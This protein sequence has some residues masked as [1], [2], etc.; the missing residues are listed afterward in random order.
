MVLVTLALFMLLAFTALAVDGGNIFVARNELHNAA[1]AGALAGARWL[2]TDDG[3]AVD[4]NANQIATDAA[5]ANDSQKASA[6]VLSARRGHW[7]FADRS[8]T[9]NPSL[10]PVDLFGQTTEELDLNPNFI[11]AVEVVTARQQTQVEAFFGK[12]LGFDGYEVAARSVAYIGFAGT[13][14][15][16][17]LDQPIALCKQALLDPADGS[18]SCDVGRFIPEGDQTGGWT[19]LQ[20]GDNGATNAN[21]LRDLVCGEGNPDQLNYGE[22][23]ETNNGQVQSAFGDFYD[24]WVEATNREVTWTLTLPV[25]DCESGVAPTN[26]LVGA[27][28]VHIVW[29]IDNNQEA[30]IDTYAPERMSLAPDSED[31]EWR[32]DWEN[33]STSGQER[34]DDFTGHFD[35]ENQDGDPADWRKM[36]IF[37][38]PSCDVHEPKGQTGGEN[39]GVLSRIPVLVD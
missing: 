11:N 24:C 13:V 38:L 22:N 30:Q 10:D 21:E 16:E 8:F 28:T 5:E 25:V 4:P 36:S 17:D 1:D 18:Y 39:F 23:I 14:R 15:P 7:S 6:E 33:T 34:W 27:V 26:E 12:V 20:H 37:F 29:V 32:G 19:N 9:A 2:Y 35:L 3:S 31:V